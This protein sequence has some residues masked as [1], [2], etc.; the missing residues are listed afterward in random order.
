VSPEPPS[1]EARAATA[2]AEPPKVEAIKIERVKVEPIKVEPIKSEP[3]KSEPTKSEPIKSTS[4][5]S[6]PAKPEPT[7]IEPA[8]R[9]AARVEPAKPV[10]LE[11]A[12]PETP[13]PE[14]AR[15]AAAASGPN[16]RAPLAAPVQEVDLGLPHLGMPSQ[17]GMP[18]G[19]KIAIAAGVL[20][21]VGAV[22]GFAMKGGGSGSTASAGPRIVEA[23][24][25]VTGEQGWITNFNTGEAGVRRTRDVSV[26]RPT[27]PLNDYRVAFEAQIESKAAGWV[28]R[29][30]DAK[31]FYVLKL[32]VV[33][34]GL[35]P[36]VA[37]VR[38]A[39]INGEDQPRTQV[40]LTIPVRV[41][42]MYKF[43]T[44]VVG[45]HM[46]TWVLDQKVD[47]WTDDRIKTGGAGLFNER[48]ERASLKGGLSVVPLAL[49]N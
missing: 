24:P 28:V 9:E 18:A 16:R 20:V 46:T 10:K 32:E 36:I 22:I 47:E 40:P 2:A 48:G 13:K 6:E 35:Q 19:K 26:L 17:P 42:T 43:R 7:G 45:N 49:R 33:K 23:G 4:I 14:L 25:P 27:M 30:A 21:A 31:N 5:K 15:P 37:F 34:P 8:K 3:T 38:F 12:K 29:A 39:V 41:D 44:D 11:P 1:P